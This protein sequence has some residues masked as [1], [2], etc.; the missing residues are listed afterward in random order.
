MN[1]NNPISDRIDAVALSQALI[2]CPSVTP[3]DAGALD[4]L[5]RT[6]GELGFACRRLRFSESGTADVD[7]LYARF[8]SGAPNFCFAGHTDV[9]PP[10]PVDHWASDPFAAE[11]RD[12][13][14]YGRGATDMK[15]AIAAFTAAC[16]RFIGERPD[17][18]G[19]ISLLITG[20]EEGPSVNGTV[21][22]LQAL[23]AEGETLDA[24]LVGEPTNPQAIGDMIK[25]G[26]RGS[27]TG[28]LTVHGVQ[29]HVAYPHLAANPIPPLMKM[30]QAIA[31]PVL[32][33]GTEHFQ[34]SNLEITTVD[35][36][37]PATNVTPGEA[38]ATFN[39]RFNTTHSGESL[40]TWL[41][42][43]VA[44]AAPSGIA[45]D[46]DIRRNS[47]PFFSPPGKLAEVVVAAVETRLG[48]TPEL[49]TTGGTSDAR[50]IKDYCPVVEFGMIGET[51]H[52]ID[53]RAELS[54]IAALTDI[55]HDV[56]ARF[57]T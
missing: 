24:C 7:N 13:V 33:E 28:F 54:D 36:G 27:L 26:R 52:K 45:Y 46:L 15:T 48:R 4:I 37:N 34:A 30:L 53:E 1:E 47:E 35:V 57:F 40:E 32:D 38:R 18:P 23:A 22:M 39:I 49:S 5:G 10:G 51:M 56:L 17:F 41:R 8:G 3:A 9:V 25:I 50:F 19:S 16:A 42:A 29:G 11:I 44:E 31:E 6:L 2:R 12:D 20:D 14:L 55:Y 21:K 43:R